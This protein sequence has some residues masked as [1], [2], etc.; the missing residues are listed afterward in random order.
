MTSPN[1]AGTA[2]QSRLNDLELIAGLA[3]RTDL[4]PVT[5]GVP[6][7]HRIW[8][9]LEAQQPVR[10]FKIRGAGYALISRRDELT[11]RGV[12]ADSGGNHSQAL[13]HAGRLLGVPVKIVM[14]TLI[15]EN[16]VQATRGFGADDGSFEL[17]TSLPDFT[18]AKEEAARIAETKGRQYLS[19]YDDEAI[20]RGA[21]TLLPEIFGQ[22]EERGA[23]MPQ[24]LHVPIGGGGLISGL[25]DANRDA[26]RP[27]AVVGHE[28]VG[29]DSAARSFHTE[30]PVDVP[31]ELNTYAEGLAVRTVGERPHQ[32][33]REGLIDSVA[34]TSMAAVGRAYLWYRRYVLPALGVVDDARVDGEGVGDPTAS[35]GRPDFSEDVWQVLPEVS[36]MVAVA[37]LL[38]HLRT[39]ESSATGPQ[40]HVLV[41]TGANTNRRAVTA[42]LEA[43]GE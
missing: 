38:E 41:I 32:R 3:Q 11:E 34:V 10:S 24:S 40:D 27:L 23:P 29:A 14:A 25:A 13:A 5:D 26:G 8:V 36:S 21:G 12:V 17:D 1:P 18:S 33:I 35:K 20:I 43:I 2:W 16:K 30:H 42:T 6:G 39:A 9:K 22:L 28:I 37:G 7:G 15:P 19:P 31:G 4:V